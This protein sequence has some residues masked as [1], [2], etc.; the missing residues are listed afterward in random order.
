[1]TIPT[2]RRPP[3]IPVP[4][5]VILDGNRRR[6]IQAVLIATAIGAL[7]WAAIGVAVW[8][9]ARRLLGG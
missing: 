5:A 4:A 6:F 3:R 8:K 7:M 9:I 1:M 2:Q